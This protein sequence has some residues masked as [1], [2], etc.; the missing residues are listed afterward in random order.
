L[1]VSYIRE[2]GEYMSRMKSGFVPGTYSHYSH[3]AGLLDELKG[4][5]AVVLQETISFE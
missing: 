5:G 2:D 1:G 4:F 3:V